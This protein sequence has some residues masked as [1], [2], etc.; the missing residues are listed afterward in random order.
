MQS[1][2]NELKK[3]FDK[4]ESYRECLF[5][6]GYL[7]SDR[8][9]ESLDEYPFYSNWSKTNIGKWKCYIH[10]DQSIYTSTDSKITV[11]LIGHAYNPFTMQY[12]EQE[13]LKDCIEAYKESKKCYFEK[14]SEFTGIHVVCLFDE[15]DD[16]VM[17][18]QDCCGMLSCFYGKA[19]DYV[20]IT[21]YPQL[22]AD[23]CDL[24][25]DE[26]VEKLINSKCYHIGNRHL[27]GDLSPYKEIK[28]LGGNTYLHYKNAFKVERFYPNEPHPEFKTQEEF[29]DGV[30][31]I[32]SLIKNGIECCTHKW[33]KRTISLSGG[34]DSKTTLAC[35]NG[36]YDKFSYFS[37]HS[38]P[39]ELVDATAAKKICDKLKIKHTFYEIPQQNEDIE[40]FDFWKKLLE[41]NTNYIKGLADN[42][43][44]KYVYLYKLNCYDIELKSWASEVARVFLE[45]KYCIK[46]PE[47]LSERHFSIFQ[48]RYFAHP[49]LL[50][51]SDRIYR[52][53]MK[54]TDLTQ[55]KFNFEHTDMFYWEVRMG[56]WGTS[57]VSSQNLYHHV[58]MPMN[59]RK[60]LEIF[61]SF[62]HDLRKSDQVHKWVMEYANN[63]V[64][65]SKEEVKNLYF[66]SYRIWMEKIYYLYRTLFYRRMK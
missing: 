59:N 26:F 37:F 40:D 31:K 29:K 53:F 8:D 5:K 38:K 21:D 34:T 60:I 24:K 41:H 33:N 52:E 20:Y 16:S 50:K 12:D 49:F 51:K 47:V 42:E 63:D 1:F 54:K 13:L 66:H 56:A 35:A 36:L 15:T 27:P 19:D 3:E 4:K 25:M 9:I 62:P 30:A 2:R 48:T 55:T 39:T 7:I 28:R 23:I 44:R 14:I 58:T 45:R 6:R 65:E 22:I 17:I 43:I 32:A 64:L 18:V 57:V 10:N 61:L 46:M 11:A